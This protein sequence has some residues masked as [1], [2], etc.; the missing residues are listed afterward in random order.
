MQWQ[1]STRGEPVDWDDA[2]ANA[3][4]IPGADLYPDRWRSDADDFRTRLAVLNRARLGVMYGHGTREIVDLF[5]PNQPAQGTMIFVHGGYWRRFDGSLWSHFSLGA[6]NSG[7]TV[8]MPTYD[9]A[10]RVRIADITRQIA[11]AVCVVANECAGPLRLVG[12]SAGGHLVARMLDP[13]VLPPEI[14]SRI[15]KVV[16]ISPVSDLRPLLNTT[17]NDD[18]KMDEAAAK[19]ESPVFMTPPSTPVTVWVGADERPVF[20]DQARWLA[21][22]WG[23]ER[24]EAPGKHHFDVIDGLKDPDS[25]LMQSILASTA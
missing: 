24:I 9:L 13:D 15:E 18:F 8:A 2:Y 4:Y 10:P 5:Q 14:S 12:H 23:C 16:P 11:Q 21:E 1:G 3:A 19:A 20:L 7:W 25:P 17:M 22:A 6:L